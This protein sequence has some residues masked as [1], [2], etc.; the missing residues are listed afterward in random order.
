MTLLA[1]GGALQRLGF[2]GSRD[3]NLSTPPQ[4]TMLAM[5][6]RMSADS[7]HA[8]HDIQIGN[9]YA[10]ETRLALKDALE[11]VGLALNSSTEFAKLLSQQKKLLD[12]HVPK[13]LQ[14]CESIYQKSAEAP[15][16]QTGLLDTETGDV[17]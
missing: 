14:L 16:H 4:R 2:D 3:L 12:R 1:Y 11:D 10:E 8:Y 6:A 7:A 5:L 15:R 13:L 17:P 9:A